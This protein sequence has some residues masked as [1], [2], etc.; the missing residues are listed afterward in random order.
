[1][2][3]TPLTDDSIADDRARGFATALRDFERSADPADLV[4]RFAD[5]ATLTRLDAGGDRTDAEAFWREYRDQFDD[6]R[7][8]FTH[9]TEGD[10]GCVLEWSSTG[11][12][13]TGRPIEYRGVTVLEFDGDA[14]SRLRTY[15]DTAA[16]IA[17][18]ASTR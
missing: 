1:M 7:T 2:D 9:A 5:G 18:P 14:V 8:T 15:Y 11:T 4:A 10:D 3:D 17:P 12:L 13:S 6:L 16:F